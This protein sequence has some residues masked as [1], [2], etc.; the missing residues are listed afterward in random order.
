MEES[1]M[2][3]LEGHLQELRPVLLTERDHSF[4]DLFDEFIQ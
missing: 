2:K 3:E 1:A 4:L